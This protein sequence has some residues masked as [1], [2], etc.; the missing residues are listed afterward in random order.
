[1]N[2]FK[3]RKFWTAIVDV[4]VSLVLYFTAKYAD[5]GMAED[6]KFLIV[7]L[8]PVFLLVI[9]G[10]AYEDAAAD[11]AQSLELNE[12]SWVLALAVTD[13]NQDCV[14]A[15]A[16][17]GQRVRRLTTGV[18]RG[19]LVEHLPVVGDRTGA[20]GVNHRA[21]HRRFAWSTDRGS[22]NG[23]QQ[24][25]GIADDDVDVPYGQ[26]VERTMRRSC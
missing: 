18:E 6:I 5:T 11:V 12:H 26:V 17:W 21:E 22:I 8:Q 10:F 23:D 9:A 25:I 20:T 13:R 2:V 24:R 14:A 3:S 7:S 19:T 16:A 4:T 15:P 1:M